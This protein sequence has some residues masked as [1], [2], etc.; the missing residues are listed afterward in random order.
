MLSLGKMVLYAFFLGVGFGV[1]Y[2]VFRIMR[3]VVGVEYLGVAKKSTDYLYSRKYP[4]I[5]KIERRENKA[6]KYFLDIFVGVGD[7]IYCLFIGGVFCIFLYY[8]N[9]GI[10]R[11]HA[12][13]AA[14]CGFFIYYKTL[15][16][17]LITFAEIICVFLKIISKILLFAIAF[18]FKFMY[19]III[20][21]LK[22]LFKPIAK[23]FILRYRRIAT[24]HRM[25][26]L[27]AEAKSGFL[28]NLVKG[29]G[30]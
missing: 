22:A 13:A 9:D 19:N 27:L 23:F 11:W 6:K 14:S 17:I 21:I 15:G 2:D 25:K 10:F 30:F 5:G 26:V 20:S 12:L 1:L 8:S 7:I 3:V 16:A 18:P 28:E 29:Q 24:K 4:L